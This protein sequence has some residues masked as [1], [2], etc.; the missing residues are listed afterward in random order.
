MDDTY[1]NKSWA[2]VGSSYFSLREV[3]QMERELFAFL[4]W[5]VVAS[6]FE[7]DN[8]VSSAEAAWSRTCQ[9]RARDASRTR[10]A[11]E[12]EARHEQAKHAA[13]ALLRPHTYRH[14]SPSSSKSSRSLSP[15]SSAQRYQ[16]NASMASSPQQTPLDAFGYPT[17]SSQAYSSQ[18]SSQ[19]SST[20]SSAFSSAF[21][22][23]VHSPSSPAS[24]PL[25]AGPQTPDNADNLDV[26]HCPRIQGA[27]DIPE[28]AAYVSTAIQKRQTWQQAQ[29]IPRS[30]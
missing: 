30:L 21:P 20:S 7:L 15:P 16:A 27:P 23:A 11:A 8:F 17:S 6:K 10:R 29:A 4:G 24:A 2:I 5:N 22:S 13:R 28:A 18:S 25:S 12:E 26:H 19:T 1:S 3:N 9:Q 14:T